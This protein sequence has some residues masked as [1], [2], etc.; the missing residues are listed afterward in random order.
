MKV[1]AHADHNS[2]MKQGKCH[3]WSLEVC[4]VTHGDQVRYLLP[5]KKVCHLHCHHVRS[6]V[7]NRTNDGSKS[8]AGKNTALNLPTVVGLFILDD[9]RRNRGLL[10]L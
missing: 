1:K 9:T 2:H 3:G 8:P 7:V 5:N 10:S 6:K 4:V